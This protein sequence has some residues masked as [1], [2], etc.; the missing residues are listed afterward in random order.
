[1]KINP[2]LGDFQGYCVNIGSG[3]AVVQC[4]MNLPFTIVSAGL[5][6]CIPVQVNQTQAL[7]CCTHCCNCY[8]HTGE[9]YKA[10]TLLRGI[11]SLCFTNKE[12]CNNKNNNVHTTS[13]IFLSFSYSKIH[14][15]KVDHLLFVA[16]LQVVGMLFVLAM[17]F[18]PE[19]L[20]EQL[21]LRVRAPQ[22][23]AL[24]ATKRDVPIASCEN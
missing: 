9:W 3:L 11:P 6:R 19:K 7:R 16:F 2:G 21:P 4:G 17:I 15:Q 22:I 20:G 10:D 5:S 12:V 13:T 18:S 23:W 8:H 1:M 14:Q 24:T